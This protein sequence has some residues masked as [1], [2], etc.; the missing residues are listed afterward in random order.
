[1]SKK[2]KMGRPPVTDK[3]KVLAFYA[4]K[5]LAESVEDVLRYTGGTVSVFLRDAVAK[6]IAGVQSDR[7]RKVFDHYKQN[8]D[9]IS[10]EIING[11]GK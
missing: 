1:M 8:S 7:K 5:E 11:G 3:G 10:T 6:E 4:P 2:A 9:G